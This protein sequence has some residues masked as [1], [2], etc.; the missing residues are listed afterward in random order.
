MNHAEN[1]HLYFGSNRSIEMFSV[2]QN[3]LELNNASNL[4]IFPVC[5][6]FEYREF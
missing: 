2:S 5:L 1:V 4:L 3:S 6:K